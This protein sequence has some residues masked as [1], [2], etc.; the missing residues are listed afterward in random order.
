MK[1]INHA[2]W[3]LTL[4]PANYTSVHPLKMRTLCTGD[5]NR[6]SISLPLSPGK[7]SR[8]NQTASR[9]TGVE[10]QQTLRRT[11]KEVSMDLRST[12]QTCKQHP[13]FLHSGVDSNKDGESINTLK[14]YAGE[15][16]CSRE[17]KSLFVIEE[18]FQDAMLV[19][20]L[21]AR[22]CLFPV[23]SNT[24]YLTQSRSQPE[25]K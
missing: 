4:D 11:I 15:N 12:T 9:I 6:G 2:N 20:N 24:P 1:E 5:N 21:L 25:N 16:C 8:T 10:D 13:K 23:H 22:N 7:L 17:N 19:L 18:H 3:P 14:V